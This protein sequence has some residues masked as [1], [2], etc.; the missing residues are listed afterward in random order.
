[1]D[2][3]KDIRVSQERAETGLG[4]E[5]DRSAAIFDAREISGIRVAEDPAAEGDK[6]WMLLL[7]WRNFRHSRNPSSELA[8]ENNGLSCLNR[9]VNNLIYAFD[10]SAMKTSKGLIISPWGDLAVLSRSA[11]ENRIWRSCPLMPLAREKS[12]ASFFSEKLRITRMVCSSDLRRK[13]K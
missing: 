5:I 4:T 13:A 11:L 10:T 1:M 12:S 7:L 9:R 3:V 2:F 6:A 8:A